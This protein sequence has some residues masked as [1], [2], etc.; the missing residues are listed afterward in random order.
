VQNKL[1]E[2]GINVKTRPVELG[3]EL[4]C[5]APKAFDLFY[6]NLLGMGVKKLFDEGHT[7]CIVTGNQY[8]DI[9]PRFLKDMVDPATKKIA[10]R[11]VNMK[12]NKCQM[13]YRHGLQYITENDYDE[14][15]KYLKN[16]E[17]YDFN[18]IVKIP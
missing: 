8:G 6:C 9:A 17:E 7:G 12:G 16:P 10:T 5:I 11:L 3:Y 18:K 4:R 2:L 13:V 15:R 14:A 1:K